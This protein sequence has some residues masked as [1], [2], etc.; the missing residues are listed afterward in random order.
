MLSRQRTNGCTCARS[1]APHRLNDKD[2]HDAYRLLQAFGTH[3]LATVFSQLR[4]HELSAAATEDA[5]GFLDELFAHSPE[6][7]GSA[8]A[9]RAEEGIGEPE[10]VA[11]A[12]YFLAR[13]LLLELG[14]R[15]TSGP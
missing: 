7:L 1:D 9:G 11:V 5:L 8:M 6:A 13:D 14:E 12:A 15:P 3:E 2:A 4:T 10:Q